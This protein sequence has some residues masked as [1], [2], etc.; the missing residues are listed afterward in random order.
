[1]ALAF[2]TDK[3]EFKPGL[4]IFR[5]GDVRHS[6]FYCRIKLL[7]ANRYKTVALD[8][9]DFEPPASWPSIKML[10][11]AFC[12]YITIPCSLARSGKLQ[13]IIASCILWAAHGL[14]RPQATLPSFIALGTARW[15][16]IRVAY[17]QAAAALDAAGQTGDQELA[18]DVRGFSTSVRA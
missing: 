6:N 2:I 17:G 15:H 3:E 13:R 14:P 18:N 10:K 11:S 1:M 9:T 4:I 8:T 5:R 7:K 16:K 12:S